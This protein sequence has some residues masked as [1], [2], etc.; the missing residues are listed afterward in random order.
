MTLYLPIAACLLISALLFA[1]LRYFEAS[2]KE[3]VA[4]Q[5]NFTVT[6]LAEDLDRKF[7]NKLRLLTDTSAKIST[8]QMGDP[9][10]AHA[11]LVS[12]SEYM[13]IFDDGLF[14][15]DTRGKIVAALHSDDA[16]SADSYPLLGE[17]ITKTVKTGKPQ[18]SD[19]FTFASG[20]RKPAMMMT[21]P[22]FGE[23]RAIIGVLTGSID[24]VK[25]GFIGSLIDHQ[26]GSTGY[27]YIFNKDR[28]MVYHPDPVRIMK[29]DI[30]LG[31]NL[32]LDKAIKGFEGT[33]ETINS[34]G[35]E[36]LAS[37]KHLKTARLILAANYPASE[38]FQ[39]LH[40]LRK[41]FAI[42]I[43]PVMLVMF[44]VMRRFFSHMTAPLAELTRHVGQ[45]T[46]K[47]GAERLFPESTLRE[48][49]E[50]GT[51]FNRLITE[52]D[53]Q[54]EEIERREQIYR[55]VVEFSSDISFWMQAG[56]GVINY[57]TP[58]CF[59][60]TGYQD[61]EFYR[62]PDLLNRIIHPDFRELWA[63][64]KLVEGTCECLEPIELALVSRTG[65]TI[66]VN[67]VCRPVY[68]EQ[69]QFCGIRGSFDNVTQIK[70]GVL[71]L[72]E[73]QK[74]L[75]RRNDFLVALH[76]T[77]LDMI[78]RLELQSLLSAIISRAAKL[79]S[80]EHGFIYLLDH[81]RQEMLMQVRLGHYASIDIPPLKRGQGMSGLTWEHGESVIVPD[82]ST[83][84]K[85]IKLP[86]FAPIRATV[87]IPLTIEN[88]VI[89]VIGLARL[90]ESSFEKD[91]IEIIQSFAELAALAIKNVQMYE[92]A[93]QALQEL[94][95]AEESLRKLSYAIKQSPVSIMITDLEGRIEY[96]NPHVLETT[97]YSQQELL[98]QKASIFK[99]GHTSEA[100][101]RKLWETIL[102]G[103]VW[104]G[105]FHNRKKNGD[106]YWE[107][108]QI[109]PIRD[110]Q[111]NITNF[112]AI[113]EDMDDRKALENQLRHAQKME[114][115]GQLAGG[116]AHDFNNILT[117]IIGYASIM[118]LKLPSG[119]PFKETARQ[120]LAAAERG[121]SLTQGLLAFS[122]K[123][124][125]NPVLVNLNDIITRIQKL[126][127][128]LITEEI[129]LKQELDSRPLSIMADGIQI[130]Q[131]VM[132]L[133][134]NARDAMPD[135]GTITI[136]TEQT[137]LDDQFIARHGF[138]TPGPYAC[139][140]VSDTGA[141]I[142]EETLKRIFDP[143][144]T[145]KETGKGTGL[146]L[147]IIY[148]IIKKHNGH[149]TCD[150]TP[151]KGTCFSI[152]LPLLA[153]SVPEEPK[154]EESSDFTGGTEVILMAEDDDSM[155][156]LYRELLVEF[157]YSVLEAKDGTDALK[158][159]GEHKQHISLA[160]LDVIMPGI[161]GLEV[162]KTIRKEKPLTP[163]L[164][165][166]GYSADIIQKQLDSDPLLHFLGKPYMPKE[167]LMKIREIL[168]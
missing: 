14:L 34:R 6:V 132:N 145:T 81:Q 104:H 50:L 106:L 61:D 60:I 59:Q 149:I 151:G 143:F 101:Y 164:F 128:P 91:E 167:L 152:Y 53:R 162:Y 122:R 75:T 165:C 146:G 35:E 166:S 97:G 113:K 12:R 120:I 141:G 136:H 89:G 27:M 126:L 121:S 13:Q 5:Q 18:V 140:S 47:T 77:T 163:V 79:L 98:G 7:D 21:A 54:Q 88:E 39:S 62:D 29:K 58:I 31:A 66:W 110:S 135:G 17:L 56:G 92:S 131:V 109:S 11:F 96:I 69:G 2:I 95:R 74:A 154:P 117:A 68:T 9:A 94:I 78:S 133:V 142:D 158:K 38:A 76:D 87:G 22:V 67:H 153:G 130:E 45:M 118:Q 84:D 108:A 155:R 32:L 65:E 119:D 70:Q 90:D 99:S 28:V 1:V 161:K 52:L 147:S 51:A 3:T 80:T 168:A 82:Y 49:D 57:I 138:G 4:N 63:Q 127:L 44:L 100:E 124:E 157:G 156:E 40:T 43:L 64:H 71:S 129:E 19:P 36:I 8:A 72:Q 73:S 42:G 48:V 46:T 33:D 16:L 125:T 55:T 30:P 159:F 93:Q 105:E 20:E 26:I 139:L 107:L 112:L 86:G 37:F 85:R 41:L 15:F 24:L 10:R 111:H 23:G 103:N 148:G 25:G 116:I 123:Q 160:I 134:T 144:Y 150:S 137:R 102:S 115:I 83:W 114:A